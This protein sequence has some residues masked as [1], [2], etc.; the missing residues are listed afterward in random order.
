MLTM[1]QDEWERQWWVW[2]EWAVVLRGKLG[3]LGPSGLI[4]RLGEWEA[5]RESP[6]SRSNATLLAS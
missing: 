2:G 3:S 4:S 6:S 1:W 5:G